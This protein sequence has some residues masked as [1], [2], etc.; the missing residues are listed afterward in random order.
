MA[1]KP[2]FEFL[3]GR[4]SVSV[5]L[6]SKLNLKYIDLLE[7]EL[8]TVFDVNW[9]LNTT[10]GV[11]PIHQN[12]YLGSG[13]FEFIGEIGDYSSI[14]FASDFV[15]GILPETILTEELIYEKMN[16]LLD[17]D[18]NST[19]NNKLKGIVEIDVSSA[20]G[21]ENGLVSVIV[22][23]YKREEHLSKTISSLVQQTYKSIEIFVVDDNGKESPFSKP[24]QKIME[25]FQDNPEVK[26]IQHKKNLNGAAARNTG[27]LHSRG[28]YICFLDD[29]DI[30]YP[31]K[32][33]KSVEKLS[34]LNNDK[35]GGV[36]CGFKGWN[37]NENELQRYKKGDLTFEFLTL[38]YEKHYLHTSSGLY[39]RSSVTR[40]N[41]FDELYRRHQDIEF[42]I[43]FFQHFEYE[44]VKEVL[45]HIR[46][47]K[48]GINNMLVNEEMFDLKEKFLNRF[49]KIIS[50]LSA[51]QQQKIYN[52]HWTHSVKLF[53]EKSKFIEY[54]DKK[55]IDGYL[56]QYKKLLL[57]M[58][59][60]KRSIL[61]EKIE[62]EVQS[63]KKELQSKKE[64]IIK[65]AQRKK[66]LLKKYG[67]LPKWFLW[68]GS[69]FKNR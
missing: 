64:K 59:E 27:I 5:I 25:G 61:F 28:E 22:P 47:Q 13:N 18:P 21:I 42:N 55:S 45:V 50:N 43:R 56:P 44:V 14:N 7:S 37:S 54:C 30:Y 66:R 41:G 40:L 23:T 2:S 26:Y 33:E 15:L 4:V 19:D 36:Y 63:L 11:R 48:T 29:D 67:H 60:K 53:D 10:M 49:K 6:S 35:I 69:I 20:T 57:E 16:Q 65:L 8:N 46:P 34:L 3:F 38:D 32:I 62:G 51:E 58:E 24:T 52:T 9:F 68:M 1:E 31:T 39:K 17:L 12:E